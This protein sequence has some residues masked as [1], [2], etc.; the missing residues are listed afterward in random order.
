MKVRA[1]KYKAIFL[2][3]STGKTSELEGGYTGSKLKTDLS[4]YAKENSL[5]LLAVFGQS[6][7]MTEF[8]VPLFIE[9]DSHNDEEVM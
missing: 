1:T 9:L 3:E 4:E 5:K 6:K 8:D 2:D 7:V